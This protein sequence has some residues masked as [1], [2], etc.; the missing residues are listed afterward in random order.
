LKL[1]T[2]PARSPRSDPCVRTW[3]YRCSGQV[4]SHTEPGLPVW[5]QSAVRIRLGSPCGLPVLARGSPQSITTLSV[6]C[7]SERGLGVC[8]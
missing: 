8:V 5:R 6:S 4:S 2:S 3:M 7:L 1:D